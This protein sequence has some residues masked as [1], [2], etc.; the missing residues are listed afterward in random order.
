MA[1]YQRMSEVVESKLMQTHPLINHVD[2]LE[3]FGPQIYANLS[4]KPQMQPS[5][6]IVQ[7]I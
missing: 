1:A 7:E 3:N 2:N 6:Q 5:V 4:H